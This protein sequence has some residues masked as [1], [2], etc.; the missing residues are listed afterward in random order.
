MR[1]SGLSWPLLVKSESAEKRRQGG[2]DTLKILLAG[3]GRGSE[4]PSLNF[5]R[6]AAEAGSNARRCGQS[7]DQFGLFQAT[8]KWFRESLTDAASQDFR[9]VG[10]I[11]KRKPTAQAA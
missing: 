4:T 8:E 7:Q 11:A 10:P 9:A 3:C 1:D 6:P 5:S 2:E